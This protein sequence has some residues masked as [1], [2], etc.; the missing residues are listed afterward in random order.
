MK[1]LAL[2]AAVVFQ[3]CFAPVLAPAAAAQG[4]AAI[5]GPP[6][7]GPM[8][9]RVSVPSVA[10]LVF[11]PV[12]SC[13][14]FDTRVRSQ[15]LVSGTQRG[16]YISGASGFAA[17]GGNSTGCGVPT[18]AVAAALAL[19]SFGANAAGSIAIAPGATTPRGIALS[20]EKGNSDTAE[21]I[22]RLGENR[23]VRIVATGGTTH[24]VGDVTGYFAHQ[25]AGTIT[26]QGE[27]YA[28]AGAILSS[29]RYGAV[30]SYVV[31][32]DRDVT[33]CS[34]NANSPYLGAGYYATGYAY[35]GNTFY[36]E[37]WK[38]VGGVSTHVDGYVN[39]TITC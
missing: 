6:A 37:V 23:N 34:V 28:N 27:I 33:F 22:T 16:F 13:R 39:F 36:L 1:R 11:V 14:A 7:P 5:K 38:I 29:G 24:L 4:G 2:V 31:T 17:Q 32:V 8:Q 20:Y 10:E 12:P 9:S 15:P 26:F 19:T 18:Y 30:G 25:I 35:N 3:A 21:T